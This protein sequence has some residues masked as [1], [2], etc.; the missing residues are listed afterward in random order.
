MFLVHR[1]DLARDGDRPVLLSGY[2]GFNISRTPAYDP[3]N[4][5]FL[6]RGGIFALANLRGGG[7]YGEDVAPRRHARA[8][9]ERLRRF[10]RRRRVPDR[11]R[12]TPGPDGSRS[13]EAATAACSSAPS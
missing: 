11:A 6:D 12:A 9:A 4:F 7:E 5:P 10:H 8:E 13:R 2:G 1:A 3:G